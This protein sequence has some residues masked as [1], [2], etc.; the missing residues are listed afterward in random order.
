MGLIEPNA[1]EQLTQGWQV[2]IPTWCAGFL[3]GRTVHHDMHNVSA[4]A[5][6]RR[7]LT[8]AISVASLTPAL[9]NIL[10]TTLP[11]KGHIYLK[12][13]V[14]VQEP[15]RPTSWNSR[16]SRL[17]TRTQGSVCI[18]H[19]WEDAT[20]SRPPKKMHTQQLQPTHQSY[21]AASSSSSSSS[22]MAS[23]GSTSRMLSA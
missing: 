5:R 20:H 6:L 9:C 12:K 2:R 15:S 11:K 10:F 16:S 17:T 19:H 1:L 3:K 4:R 7:S 13:H 14:P 23:S 18:P 8:S 22:S 21:T